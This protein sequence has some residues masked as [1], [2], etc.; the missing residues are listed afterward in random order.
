M[1]S[2]L[3]PGPLR[4]LLLT[5]KPLLE[6]SGEAII[7][8]TDDGQIAYSNSRAAELFGVE[9]ASAHR[10]SAFSIF[11]DL[12]A[13]SWSLI[14]ASGT[15]TGTVYR[16]S[17]LGSMIPITVKRSFQSLTETNPAYV[18]EVCRPHEGSG[19]H[20]DQTRELVQSV[21]ASG[22]LIYANRAWYQKLGY[23]PEQAREMTFFDWV[24]P[25]SHA[26]C[27][28]IFEKLMS[29]ESVGQ[30]STYF[31]DSEGASFPVRGSLE[32]VTE[33]GKPVA[34]R[35]FFRCIDEEE[36]FREASQNFFRLTVDMLCITDSRGYIQYLNPAWEDFL[37][38]TQDELKGRAITE[39][40]H[41]E[42][43]ARLVQET[44][45][46]VVADDG[47]TVNFSH[48]I[49]N[50]DGEYRTIV[51]S[52]VSEGDF[53]YGVARDVTEHHKLTADLSDQKERLRALF[54]I[55]DE[56]VFTIDEL[57][58]IE[59]LNPAA[60]R[61]FGRPSPSTET[62][63]LSELLR[64]TL[65]L[66]GG[67]HESTGIRGDGTEFPV[68]VTISSLTLND[69]S[70][71]IVS[72]RDI[73]EFLEREKVLNEAIDSAQAANQAKSAFLAAMSH[74]LRT[75]LNAVLGFSELLADQTFGEINSKQA[76]YVNN[77]L[78]GGQHLLEL[79]DGVLDLSKI[80]AGHID[81]NPSKL[82]LTY[83]LEQVVKPLS[84]LLQEK[85][86]TLELSLGGEWWVWADVIRLRQVLWNLLSNAVKFTPS[87]GRIQ[88]KI[89]RIP[90]GQVRVCVKDNGLGLSEANQRRIFD[91][92]EQVE[93]KELSQSSG[94]GLG[95]TLSSRLLEL[96][97][98]RLWVE[99]PGE[100]Q[101]SSFFFTLPLMEESQ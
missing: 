30:V 47:P 57:G 25:S 34:T 79:I 56:S 5:L 9:L 68:S 10:A 86:H 91:R 64:L 93:S 45:R 90:D 65:P 77:I 61:L 58:R 96:L 83:T 39:F 100:G 80:E 4:P 59:S 27:Q 31:V 1:K 32:W 51:W 33:R 40:V 98:G 63:H 38:F 69:R 11:G 24:H 85:E 92:F 74:E 35:S 101:G 8:Y 12:D 19:E 75:P 97:G 72:V 21:D 37:G 48:R 2:A 41:P 49:K 14:R 20:L 23:S 89:E 54:A 62:I 26:H 13:E 36:R 73:S 87:Q 60:E 17:A 67:T 50:R 81:L 15:W 7:L 84:G 46:L 99:S 43:E 76:R 42:D 78:T 28:R 6:A 66:I 55:L 88:V 82:D 71:M 16:R 22:R 94:A 70:L 52:A 18:L 29:G 44:R 95:L 3:E 53:A